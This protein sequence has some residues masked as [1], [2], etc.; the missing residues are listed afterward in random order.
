MDLFECYNVDNGEGLKIFLEASGL[1]VEK[2]SGLSG[3]QN[4]IFLPDLT[5]FNWKGRDRIVR[6]N[7]KENAMHVIESKSH[8]SHFDNGPGDPTRPYSFK[9]DSFPDLIDAVYLLKTIEGNK[10]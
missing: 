9:V 8:L 4:C 1:I 3:S 6:I 7:C 2:T 10:R 5:S